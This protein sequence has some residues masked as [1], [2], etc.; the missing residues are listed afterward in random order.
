MKYRCRS[1]KYLAGTE[2]R[3]NP[4]S[5]NMATGRAF[6]VVR[7]DDWC[8]EHKLQRKE[9]ELPIQ[10]KKPKWPGERP[11]KAA[12]IEM[13]LRGEWDP[14]KYPEPTPMVYL[15]LLEALSDA[16]SGD[17]GRLAWTKTNLDPLKQALEAR[18]TPSYL[19]KACYGWKYDPS[20]W[21]NGKQE[22]ERPKDPSTRLVVRHAIKFHRWYEEQTMHDGTKEER[23]AWLKGVRG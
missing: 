20:G 16:I 6:P 2:C 11:G 13:M 21:W 5:F 8:G 19:A 15:G 22:G 23:P 1:C 7:E 17:K 3:R 10:P 14:P 4:P 9:P 12:S 18:M